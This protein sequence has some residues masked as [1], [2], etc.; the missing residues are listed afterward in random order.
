VV[1][2]KTVHQIVDRMDVRS[3]RIWRIINRDAEGKEFTFHGVYHEVT[4]PSRLVYTFEWEGMPGHVLLGTVTFKELDG[5][6]KVTEKSVFET[7]EDRDGMMKSGMEE[8]GSETMDRLAELLATM[9][10]GKGR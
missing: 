9:N 10:R 5:R 4:W 7:V 2:T 1:G 6:T 3:G 8:G